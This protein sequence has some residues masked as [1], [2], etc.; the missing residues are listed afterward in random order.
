MGDFFDETTFSDKPIKAKPDWKPLR[1]KKLWP[2]AKC[3]SENVVCI[4]S[5]GGGC[6]IGYSFENE[7]FCYDCKHYTLYEWGYES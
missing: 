2:C 4:H 1:D 3:G 5:E 7:Y 6:I